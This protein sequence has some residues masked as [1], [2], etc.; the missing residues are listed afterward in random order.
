MT[1]QLYLSTDNG[2]NQFWTET[3]QLELNNATA[4]VKRLYGEDVTIV[5]Q[6][7]EAKDDGR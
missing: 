5:N 4:Q 6:R 2:G 1:W 3:N 7:F